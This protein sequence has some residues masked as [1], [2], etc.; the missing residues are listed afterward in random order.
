MPC[1]PGGKTATVRVTVLQPV[2][3]VELKATGKAVPGGNVIVSATIQPKNAG[4]KKT[5]WSLDVGEDIATVDARGRVHI[6]RDTPAGTVIT[7]TCTAEGAKV[8]VVQTIQI[9]VAEK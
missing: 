5:A 1:K 8:P 7:V 9:E 3:S 2:E 4:D 6:N